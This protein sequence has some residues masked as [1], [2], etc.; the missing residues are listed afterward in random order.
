M[1]RVFS[2]NLGSQR[3][4]DQTLGFVERAA[5]QRHRRSRAEFPLREE[6]L[7]QSRIE[8]AHAVDGRD[9]AFHVAQFQQQSRTAENARASRLRDRWRAPPSPPFR[10]AS[11]S[12]CSVSCGSHGKSASAPRLVASAAGSPSLRAIVDRLAT[13]ALSPRST[14]PVCSRSRASDPMSLIRSRTSVSG[15]PA[16]AS[17]SS[18]PDRESTCAEWRQAASA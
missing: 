3:L 11:G 16:R 4:K 8:I 12:I 15:K 13:P 5:H 18:R 7:P 6:R 9:G 14:L 1:I 10:L 2:G 17:S